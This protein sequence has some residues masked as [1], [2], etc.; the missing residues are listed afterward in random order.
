MGVIASLKGVKKVE[1]RIKLGW[2]EMRMRVGLR[3]GREGGWRFR[4]GM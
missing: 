4:L 3:E 2:L 1:F